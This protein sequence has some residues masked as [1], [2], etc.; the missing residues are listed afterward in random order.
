MST[1]ASIQI[2]DCFFYQSHDGYPQDVIDELQKIV[3]EAQE[4]SQKNPDMPF[5]KMMQHLMREYEFDE[6]DSHCGGDYT[7]E[8]K[9]DG[10]IFVENP[11]PFMVEVSILDGKIKVVDGAWECTYDD[12]SDYEDY[13][14]Y[15]KEKIDK[16]LETLT[17]KDIQKI[18]NNN[19]P[20]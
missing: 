5:T 1:S 17:E 16:R 13:C 3:K 19:S 12:W 15:S 6:V 18:L 14:E 8:V 4:K 11:Y 9:E 2:G 7:Y 10:K 20:E